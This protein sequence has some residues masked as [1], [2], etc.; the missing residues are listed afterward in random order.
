MVECDVPGG[1][2]RCGGQ[3]DFL[4]GTLGTF[5]AWAQRFQERAE[6]GESLPSLPAERLPLL[7]A[8]GASAVT[9]TASKAA[10]ERHGR[11]MLAHDLLPEIGPAYESLFPSS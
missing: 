6:E 4:S 9:R 8:Y 3:G 2:K 7:A 11:S 10:F 1:L 5:L